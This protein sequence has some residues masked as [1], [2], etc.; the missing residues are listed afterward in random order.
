MELTAARLT[1]LI[2]PKAFVV[3][4]CVIKV[5]GVRAD[6]DREASDNWIGELATELAQDAVPSQREAVLPDFVGDLAAAY[7]YLWRA[8]RMAP[9]QWMEHEHAKLAAARDARIARLGTE[10]DYRDKT[11]AG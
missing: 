2:A 10:A 5:I 11:A 8:S 3:R 6:L 7:T 1:D 4:H 9:L